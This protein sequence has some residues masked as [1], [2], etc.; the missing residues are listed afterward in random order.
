MIGPDAPLTEHGNA[1]APGTVSPSRRLGLVVA[2]IVVTVWVIYLAYITIRTANPPVI[3]RVQIDAADF[4][5]LGRWENFST[6]RFRV[7]R[8][9]KH[10]RLT[11]L[12]QVLGLP[13]HLPS[14]S[15]EWV[16]PVSKT[17]DAVSV[18]QGIYENRPLHSGQNLNGVWKVRVAPQC[19]PATAEILRQIDHELAARR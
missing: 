17:G 12:V 11:G 15:I 16:I 8:E 9:L 1:A 13:D 14:Q 19:Y 3:N 10:G 2:A 6:G 18:T 5:L 4:L 7:E